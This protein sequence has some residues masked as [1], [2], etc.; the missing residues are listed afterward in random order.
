MHTT[1]NQV[2]LTV[3]GQRRM[4]RL[5]ALLHWTMIIMTGGL[6]LPVYWIHR[7]RTTRVRY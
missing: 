3:A 7:A 4:S 1:I 2:Q 6:W 5:A